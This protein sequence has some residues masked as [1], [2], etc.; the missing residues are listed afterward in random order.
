M[1]HKR[2]NQQAKCEVFFVAVQVKDEQLE[3]ALVAKQELEES[4]RRA[5]TDNATS[6]TDVHSPPAMHGNEV[7][8]EELELL[9]ERVAALAARKLL[10]GKH[11]R[12]QPGR[13]PA[14]LEELNGAY[15]EIACL[16]DIRC[17]CWGRALLYCHCDVPCAAVYPEISSNRRLSSPAEHV[18]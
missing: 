11:P 1:W 3:E 4:C 16:Y 12:G 10:T 5:A 9:K 17:G 7:L 8:K 18:F 6:C 14:A 13:G 2:A 15:E